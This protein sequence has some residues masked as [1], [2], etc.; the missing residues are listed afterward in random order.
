MVPCNCDLIVNGSYIC[1]EDEDRFKITSNVDATNLETTIALPA[2]TTYFSSTATHGTIDDTDP[3][4]PIWDIPLLLKTEE[5][6]L[7]ICVEVTDVIAFS[8]TNRLATATVTTYPSEV[9]TADNVI[10]RELSGTTCADLSKCTAGEASVTNTTYNVTVESYIEIDTSL[11]N[12][13]VNLPATPFQW[14]VVH[15][16]LQDNTNTATVDANGSTMDGLATIDLSVEDE[17]LKVVYNGTDWSI[18]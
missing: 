1:L 8:A 11:N 18:Y 16:K 2:G 6:Y 3:L 13:T 9:D 12:V 7:R 4:N 5:A 14:Q 15:I 10:T 17:T